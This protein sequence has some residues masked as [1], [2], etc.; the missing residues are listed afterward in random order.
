MSDNADTLGPTLNRPAA[1]A[2]EAVGHRLVHDCLGAGGSLLT[3]GIP[4]WTD[5][6]LTELHEYFVQR[7]DL[8]AKSFFEKLDGQ[9]G[10]RSHGAI[11][12]FAEIF[13]LNVLPITNVSGPKKVEQT[14]SI[15]RIGG[16]SVELPEDVLDALMSGGV[17]NGGQAF[18]TQKWKQIN[19]LIELTRAFRELPA[20]DA[21]AVLSDPLTFRG[22]VRTIKTGQAAQRQALL[23]L[24]FPEFYL[25]VV[26]ATHLKLIRDAFA[27]E[28]LGQ[29]PTEDIDVD[30]HHI[31][32]NIIAAEGK[33]VDLYTPPWAEKWQPSKSQPEPDPGTAH[34]WRIYGSNVAGTDMVPVWQQKS[35]VSLAAKFLRPV[36]SDIS[37]DNLKSIV[38]KDYST[39]NYTARKEKT[40]EFYSFLT[41]MNPGDLVVTVSQ[42]K[43]YFGTVTGDA[44]YADDSAGRSKL[45]RPV[46]WYEESITTA[47]LPPELSTRLNEKGEVLDLTGQIDTI[48]T[49]I[50]LPRPTP[51]DSSLHLPDADEYLAEQL[52]VDQD[53]LQ[54]CID[55]IRDRP[56]LIFYGPPGTGKTYIAKTL[57]RYLAGEDK[58]KIVQFHPAYSYEDFFEGYRPG[59]QTGG[60]VGFDL[61]KGPLRR[62]VDRAIES[63]QAPFVLIIDE[64]NRGNLAKIFG[65][66]YFL[67]E[68]RNE[69]IDLMYS[70]APFTLP[71]NIVIIGTMNTADRS[72]ALVDAAMRRR[73]SFVTLHP[74]QDPANGV[75]RSWLTATDRPTDVADL[76]DELNALIED[77]DFKIGPS[78]F[79]RESAFTDTGLQRIWRTSILPLLEEHHYGDGINI[80]QRY[81]LD[82]IRKRVAAHIDAQ[83]ES[84]G[85]ATITADTD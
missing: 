37:F 49:P 77:D 41:Q 27:E 4:V 36:N 55:L 76:L 44:T 79:M 46:H 81:G 16:D 71:R 11:Q 84:L 30:L 7:P 12:L 73:F 54:E 51:A 9:I 19:Y 5:R 31:Y 50:A 21:A 1:P 38:D 69:S 83:T 33:S 24:A 34:A 14:K 80:E 47:Q 62:L 74:S 65:E 63:P 72:I 85:D 42:G 18:T 2:V 64:I 26:S 58:V 52:N 17:F 25:P 3:P 15:L 61:R 29:E 66:L 32:S 78:Y 28:Y 56:Q 82:T 75:L 45:R 57:A 68:Y 43:V 6:N 60:Q 53:W 13:I 67:L 8:S 20:E 70:T 40:E 48:R 22:F 23:Y 35:S 39:V 10:S 59:Q